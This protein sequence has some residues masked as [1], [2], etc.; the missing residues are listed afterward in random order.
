MTTA[1]M[2]SDVSHWL[3]ELDDHFLVALHAMVGTYVSQQKKDTIFGYDADG[4]VLHAEDMKSVYAAEVAGVKR[5][6][7][8][9]IDDFEKQSETW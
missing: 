8:L 1:D 9:S 6:E 5:G 2:R 3:D 4:T 7:Y